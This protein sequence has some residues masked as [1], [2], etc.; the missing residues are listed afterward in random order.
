MS[1][2]INRK[3]AFEDSDTEYEPSLPGTGRR[4]TES[5]FDEESNPRENR[6]KR[7]RRTQLPRELEALKEICH[8]IS[9]LGD[10][11]DR[12]ESDWRSLSNTI[13]QEFDSGEFKQNLLDYIYAVIIE[14]PH[15]VF[16][17]SGLVQ[18]CH[19]LNP[20]VGKAVI[21]HMKQN[22]ESLLDQNVAINESDEPGRFT[23]LKLIGRFLATLIPI[24]ES[25]D[26][27]IDF[28]KQM[29]AAAVKVQA[30]S[31]KR[32][33]IAEVVY[34]G[35]T[36]SIPFV[37]ASDRGGEELKQ[38]C[39]ELID[40][41][42]SFEIKESKYPVELFQHFKTSDDDKP[43]PYEPKPLVS[44][45][46]DAVKN[47]EDCINIFPDL[48]KRIDAV[49]GDQKEDIEKVSLT[50][51]TV[52]SLNSAEDEI[53]LYGTVDSLWK[54]PRFALEIFSRPKGAAFSAIPPVDSYVSLLMRDLIQDLV[55]NSEFNRITVSR[56]LL[57]LIKYI[58]SKMFAK[59]N[60]S[61]DKLT[62]VND[63]RNGVDLIN[64]LETNPDIP[65]S[66]KETMLNSAKKIEL[67]FND[68]YK[69][70]WKM[71][72]V[73]TESVLDLMLH[74]PEST[75]PAIYYETLLAD[76]CGRDW[77]LMKRSEDSHE[78]V[79][80]A[81]TIAVTIKYLY[82]NVQTIDFDIRARVVCWIMIQLSS[83]N[84]DW[85]W[86]DWVDDVAKFEQEVYHPTFFLLHNIIAKE[87][88]VSTP[89]S[90]RSTI[91]KD[92]WKF[93]DLSLMS[94]DRVIEYDSQFFGQSLA[95]SCY[96]SC[97]KAIKDEMNSD[98]SSNDDFGNAET[99]HLLDQYLF[100]NSE[101]PQHDLCHSIYTNL[102][103][104]ETMESFEGLLN[105]VR[106]QISESVDNVEKYIVALV[107]ESVCIIGSRSLSVIEGGALE[108]CGD[109]LRSV[110]G[111]GEERQK[112][113]IEAV[114]RLWNHEPRIGYLVLE[115]MRNK[116]F[117]KSSQVIESLFD[118]SN[119]RVLA[120][121]E[122]Y[123]DE[124]LNRLLF[125]E[126]E[127]ETETQQEK[128]KVFGRVSISALNRLAQGK[129][130]IKET[131]GIIESKLRRIK[132]K[133]LVQQMKQA[134]SDISEESVK[135]EAL[136]KLELFEH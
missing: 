88:R 123:A 94:R 101:H 134:A 24:M 57:S 109:K 6:Y 98:S 44:L 60:S 47:L 69:S 108:L 118:L 5:E 126:A 132:S 105:D 59:P 19:A 64:D 67:E 111:E 92:F 124:L 13:S 72:Q 110:L 23:R 74:L 61:E 89:R 129:W 33:A 52:G 97:A 66:M 45:V 36:L 41:A 15:K 128:Q 10:P 43:L 27:V 39:S 103:E 100:N 8:V 46:L 7:P 62:I 37:L 90:I 83:F 58:N 18:C 50:T 51:F 75:L 42:G 82:R 29:I 133:E 56:Q 30:E 48:Q 135:V 104:G 9:Q 40:L 102:Q 121:T 127:N 125:E 87:V 99:F 26:F 16:V 136:R 63:M 84:F 106:K 31:A 77:T 32:S 130:A 55:Q 80:F 14:Q 38:K 76:T 70:T 11:E 21:E 28:I 114:L 71:E 65:E 113:L 95:E 79:A 4:P 81:K 115:K 86:A 17:M 20:E 116:K 3:R 54:Y 120:V 85:Q 91:P 96:D 117:I 1:E 68:G 78:K 93:T 49:I 122:I 119:G 25:A 12:L 107:V 22:V 53:G 35:F 131:L 112:W 2:L 73:I 34:Y